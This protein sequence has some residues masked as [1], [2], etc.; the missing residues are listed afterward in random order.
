M[1]VGDLCSIILS[2]IT[3]ERHTGRIFNITGRE[4][5]YY[6]DIV[7][8]IRDVQGLRTLTV[9]VPYSIFWLLLRIYAL[10]DSD[11]PFTTD[12]LAALVAGDEFE[13][14]PWWEI[15]RVPSTPFQEAIR[16]TYCD[17]RYSH[18]VLH[19]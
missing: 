17:T 8:S 14:I 10:F 13:L 19:F 6:A 11:P 7:R 15:F 1:Y 5:L 9:P 12:Q 2:C 4:K 18:H 3:G 16:E